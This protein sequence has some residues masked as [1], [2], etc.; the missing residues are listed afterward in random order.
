MTSTVL[1]K[2]SEVDAAHTWDTES[3]FKD[4][5]AW[6]AAL[7]GL[8]ADLPSLTAF[9]GKL[10]DPQQLLAF[11]EARDAYEI[12]F[13]KLYT[14]AGMGSS[15]DAEDSAASAGYPGADRLWRVHVRASVW[16]PQVLSLTWSAPEFAAQLAALGQ[17][18]GDP[19]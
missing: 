2:R 19:R 12:Q 13:N 15:V 18:E 14:Y 4:V 16:R 17:W 8:R 7:N 11:L 1:P 5:S 9:N 3:I 10:S 6:E